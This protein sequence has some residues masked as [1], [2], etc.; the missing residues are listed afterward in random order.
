MA[1]RRSQSSHCLPLANSCFGAIRRG[2]SLDA[3]PLARLA[4]NACGCVCGFVE[5]KPASGI[6]WATHV[7]AA[8]VEHLRVNQRRRHAAIAEEFLHGAEA[9][10]G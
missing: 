3:E 8:A 4:L 5:R 1:A 10:P 2:P 9:L 7:P 6:Q